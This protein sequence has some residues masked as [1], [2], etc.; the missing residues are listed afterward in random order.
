MPAR[1]STRSRPNRY[2]GKE[3]PPSDFSWVAATTT[4]VKEAAI[5]R[6]TSFVGVDRFA[7]VVESG[8]V[9]AGVSETA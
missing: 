4:A 2:S 3:F 6:I 5:G 8:D 7:G 1:T 9:V